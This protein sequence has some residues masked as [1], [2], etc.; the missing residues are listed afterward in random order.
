MRGM[1]QLNSLQVVRLRLR[2]IKFIRTKVDQ[3]HQG[4]LEQHPSS[5]VTS[6][7]STFPVSGYLG[8]PRHPKWGVS[9]RTRGASL[10]DKHCNAGRRQAPDSKLASKNSQTACE[11]G[12]PA[13]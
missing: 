4:H 8:R 12:A 5:D 10:Q 9:S 13:R 11:G 3:L 6:C 1:V 2:Q 7:L